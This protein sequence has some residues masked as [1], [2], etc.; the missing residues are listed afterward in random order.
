MKQHLHSQHKITISPRTQSR[1]FTVP[2][3]T[4]AITLRP[5]QHV[6]MDGKRFILRGQPI[7]TIPTTTIPEVHQ[8]PNNHLCMPDEES[9]SENSVNAFHHCY[10]PPEPSE[11]NAESVQRAEEINERIGLRK[12][13]RKQ[14]KQHVQ[15]VTLDDLNPHG[16]YPHHDLPLPAQPITVIYD[17]M[18]SMSSLSLLTTILDSSM[19]NSN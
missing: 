12:L 5:G 3:L 13:K 16:L 14:Y 1:I 18:C 2:N 19:S 11:S 8:D 4:D 9:S 10:I 6:I 7:T 15:T 17:M